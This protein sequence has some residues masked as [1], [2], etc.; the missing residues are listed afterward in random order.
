MWSLL[1]TDM[2]QLLLELPSEE[3]DYFSETVLRWRWVERQA[4]TLGV[5]RLLE[6]AASVS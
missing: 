2:A 3:L 1:F 4:E 6:E 5:G